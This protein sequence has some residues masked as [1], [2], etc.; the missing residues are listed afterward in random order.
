[1]ANWDTIRPLNRAPIPGERRIRTPVGPP[2]RN[3][4]KIDCSWINYIN[5]QVARGY[6]PYLVT[7]PFAQLRGGE[8]AR[9]DQMK[10]RVEEFRDRVCARTY[11]YPGK[12]V[13]KDW[14]PIMVVVPETS[15]ANAATMKEVRLAR[16]NDGLHIHAILL[17]PP[18][19]RFKPNFLQAFE[20]K[21]RSLYLQQR[22][23]LRDIHVK[24]IRDGSVGQVWSYLRKERRRPGQRADEFSPYPL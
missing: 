2:R 12:P 15:W 11:R 22:D 17:I 23:I 18:G 13:N 3:L 21:K 7:F 14:P 20:E 19:N 10:K 1:M 9:L 8:M 24:P 16:P 4:T 6:E 5:D